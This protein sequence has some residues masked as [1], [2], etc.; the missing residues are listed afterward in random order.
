MFTI[1]IDILRRDEDPLL[2]RTLLYSD[3]VDFSAK[4]RIGNI[5]SSIDA[6][7]RFLQERFEL[8]EFSNPL[9]FNS[10][11]SEHCCEL[12]LIGSQK[13]L[14][15]IRSYLQIMDLFGSRCDIDRSLHQ[16]SFKKYLFS[17]IQEEFNN[18]EINP[19]AFLFPYWVCGMSDLSWTERLSILR[20]NYRV[21]TRNGLSFQYWPQA[22]LSHVIFSGELEFFLDVLDPSPTMQFCF[23][24]QLLAIGLKSFMSSILDNLSYNTSMGYTIFSNMGNESSVGI[25]MIVTSNGASRFSAIDWEKCTRP[26]GS[27]VAQFIRFELSADDTSDEFKDR[28]EEYA[29]RVQYLIDVYESPL[30]LQQ[31]ARLAVRET[32]SGP[33][34]EKRMR[35]LPLPPLILDFLIFADEL[36]YA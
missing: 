33:Q 6:F 12:N 32:V 10:T 17:N 28:I 29:A 19:F 23:Q 30:T 14:A 11:Q 36:L 20:E 18:T 26:D 22:D 4:V 35:S 24:L 25:S 5:G 3:V 8:M 9:A 34:F 1:E 16:R 2:T 15:T 13:D 7:N 31:L 27:L 21:Y